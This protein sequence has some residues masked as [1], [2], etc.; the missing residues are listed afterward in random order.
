MVRMFALAGETRGCVGQAWLL[1]AAAHRA[2]ATLCP[3]RLTACGMHAGQGSK[4]A[5]VQH[6]AAHAARPVAILLHTTL[7]LTLLPRAGAR[8]DWFSGLSSAADSAAARRRSS[9][10]APR[11]R[12]P[13]SSSAGRPRRASRAAA[14][15]RATSAASAPSAAASSPRRSSSTAPARGRS[16]RR[17]LADTR[18]QDRPGAQLMATACLQRA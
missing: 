3:A 10:S 16:L 13:S 18:A 8:R 5:A 2:A 4:A 14:S 1:D 9:S 17:V 11:R 7:A 15:A 6:P 12:A